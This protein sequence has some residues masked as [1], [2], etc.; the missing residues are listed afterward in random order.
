[1]KK[2]GFEI[3]NNGFSNARK[4]AQLFGAG[5]DVPKKPSDGSPMLLSDDMVVTS[6]TTTTSSGSAAQQGGSNSAQMLLFCEEF[7]C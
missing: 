1:M 7:N 3:S 6:T 4:H 5:E 2:F